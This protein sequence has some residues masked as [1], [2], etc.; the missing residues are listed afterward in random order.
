MRAYPEEWTVWRRD[1]NG[2]HFVVQTGLSYEQAQ[3]VVSS[4]EAKGH[5]QFFWLQPTGENPKPRQ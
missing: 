4:L 2:N 5:K 3:A 1:D